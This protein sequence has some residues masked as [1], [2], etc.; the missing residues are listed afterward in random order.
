[1]DY[2]DYANITS[3]PAARYA[4]SPKDPALNFPPL[5]SYRNRAVPRLDAETAAI[6]VIMYRIT[7]R[8]YSDAMI[9]AV[10]RGVPVRLLTEPDQ[11]RDPT[12]YW[13]SWN[14]DRMYTAGVQVRHRGHAGLNHQKSVVLRGQ[15]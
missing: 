1:M 9:R 11:Y 15:A 8:H 10:R 14:V 3:P 6:D 2:G 5:E 4:P 12:R 7:D 13:H